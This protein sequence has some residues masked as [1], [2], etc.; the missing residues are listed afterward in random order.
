MKSP[1]K[2]PVDVRGGN[3]GR[4]GVLAGLVAIGG[5]MLL[6]RPLHA[7]TIGGATTQVRRIVSVGGAMTEIVFALGDGGRLVAVDTTSLYPAQATAAL[8]KVGYLRTLST[9]GVLSTKPDLIL[10]DADAGPTDVIDQLQRLGAPLARFKER[11]SAASISDKIVFVGAALHQAEEAAKMAALFRQDLA[12]VTAGV[13]KLQ[14]QP[15]VLFLMNAGATGLRG[16]GSNTAAAEMIVLAGGR[17]VFAQTSGYKAVSAEAALIANPDVILMMSQTVAELGGAEAI[18]DLPVLA[19]TKAA[20][21][22]RIFGFDGNY[23]LGF[24]PRTAHAVADL[25]GVLH[26]QDSISAPPPR[27]WTT[28]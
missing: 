15:S 8:P 6:R 10:L 27:P 13:D 22:R 20:R 25:A 11:P 5:V 23:L 16:A 26:P 24:G 17:N 14:Q 21:N 3:I 19:K 7:E 2:A 1:V 4:R 18:A 9:E 28:A 12:E